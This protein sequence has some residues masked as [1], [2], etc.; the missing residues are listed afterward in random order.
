[1][2]DASVLARLRKSHGCL[3]AQRVVKQKLDFETAPGTPDATGSGAELGKTSGKDAAARKQ[4]L[5]R[6]VGMEEGWQMA[7]SLV[8]QATDALASFGS[9]A[10]PLIDLARFVIERRS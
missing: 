5:P 3:T 9:A 7:Q 2:V 6:A 8:A 10:G 1:M 4:S